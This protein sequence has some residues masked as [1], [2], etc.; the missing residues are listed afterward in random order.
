MAYTLKQDANGLYTYSS[1]M[2]KKILGYKVT[3]VVGK[4]Y[5]FDF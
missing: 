2:I 5:F 3:E 4:R 1:P